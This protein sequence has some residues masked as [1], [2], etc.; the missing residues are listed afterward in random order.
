MASQKSRRIFLIL[1]SPK[2]REYVIEAKKYQVN[3]K[4]PNINLSQKGFTLR[5]GQI[6]FGLAS[7]KKI[8]RDF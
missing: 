3:V 1:A 8:R 2:I 5:Q 7:I 6:Y 4:G